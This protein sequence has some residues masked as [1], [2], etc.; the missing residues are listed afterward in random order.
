MARLM[1]AAMPIPGL[2]DPVPVPRALPAGDDA[3]VDLV[4]LSREAIRVAIEEAGLDAR[5]AKLPAKQIWH[6]IYNRRVTEFASMSDVAKPQ[7]AW[8][9][10]RFTI[11]R[12]EVIEDHVHKNGR[13]HVGTQATNADL[14]C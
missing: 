4:G 5:Q 7:R 9:A 1:T 12:P 8:F 11:R 3:R 6:Q 10:E 2:I 13:V 14:V